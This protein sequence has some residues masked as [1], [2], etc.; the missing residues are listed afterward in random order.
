MDADVIDIS[1]D[2]EAQLQELHEDETFV[3]RAPRR[4]WVDACATCDDRPLWGCK[5]FGCNPKESCF[6]LC[7]S[8]GK[9]GFEPAINGWVP[10][11]ETAALLLEKLG[12]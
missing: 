6:L 10:D 3:Y 2:V 9:Y 12:R 4:V 11:W 5:A 7:P 8:C 1:D